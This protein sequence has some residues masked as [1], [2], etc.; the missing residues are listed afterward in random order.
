M[1]KIDRRLHLVLPLV[2]GDG[3]DKKIRGYVH[4]T[5]IPSEVFHTYYKPMGR[6]MNAIYRDSLGLM[7]ARL[8]HLILK[9]AAIELNM[10][11]GEAGVERGL[12]GEIYRQTLVMLPGKNGWES[13][14]YAQAKLEDRD[15]VDGAIVYFILASA[16]HRR[17]EA[18]PI[19]NSASNLWSA[20]TESLSSTEF[21]NSL[22]TST[23][24]ENSGET[25]AA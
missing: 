1:L 23:K 16:L 13:V 10:W 11:E 20:R 25:A 21:L 4:S 2:E 24:D 17:A 8:A 9:D 15:E 5:A 22:R 19:I 12:M 7:S 14:P 3:K 18:E 6:A